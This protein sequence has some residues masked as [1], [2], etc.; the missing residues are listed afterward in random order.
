MHP[1]ART[2]ALLLALTLAWLPLSAGAEARE[3]EGTVAILPAARLARGPAGV[4]NG[5]AA[6]A[7]VLAFGFKPTA[8]SEVG[9]DVGATALGVRANDGRYDVVGVPILLRGSWSPAPRW[10]VR[11]VLHAG[12]GKELVLVYGP[13]DVYREHTPLALMAAAGIAADLSNEI[14]LSADLGYLYGRADDPG[15]GRLDGGG[16][17]IRAGVYFRW[18][19]VQRLGR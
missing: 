19:P 16:G 13:G 6:P 14:G 17:F 3:R 1:G 18:D 11:P 5:G 10:D 15:L 8:S 9:I 2:G 7:M 12:L 4:E